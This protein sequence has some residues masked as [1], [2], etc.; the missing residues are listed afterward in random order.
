[1]VPQTLSLVSIVAQA[2]TV[3]VAGPVRLESS[4]P[5]LP[6]VLPA[7]LSVA[8]SAVVSWAI[9]HFTQRSDRKQRLNAQIDRLV[10][11][12]MQYALMENDAFCTAWNENDTSAD[13]MR[14]ENYCCFVYNLLQGIWEFCRGNENNIQSMLDCQ[15][16]IWRHSTW[17]RQKE[18]QT[19]YPDKFVDYV[20]EVAV[21]KESK[22]Q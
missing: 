16:L 10:E 17:W 5:L 20:R 18:H 4:N 12:G 2:C 14:Y 13:A 1:M 22:S 9:W 19:G 7:L 8:I 11:L 6:L 3:A 21:R 15:D